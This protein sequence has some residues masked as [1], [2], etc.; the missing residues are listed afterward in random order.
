MTLAEAAAIV[1]RR[2][3]DSK[4]AESTNAVDLHGNPLD[5]PPRFPLGASVECNLGEGEWVVGTV[6]GHHYRQAD[7]PEDRRAPYQVQVEGGGDRTIFVPLDR[8]ELV[9]TTLRFPLMSTVE[10]FLGEEHGW[11][12]G[13]VVAHY[14]REPSWDPIK[15]APYQI[16]LEDGKGGSALIFAPVDNDSCVR[17]SFLSRG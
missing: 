1:E 4:L 6:V 7:W 12:I 8:D 11:A 9:R 13:T 2:Q 5:G 15:W 17:A 16:K 10:C 3:N 14:H